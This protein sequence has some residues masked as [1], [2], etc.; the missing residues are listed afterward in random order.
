MTETDPKTLQ[1]PPDVRRYD[2]DWLR[3]IAF[4]LLIFYHIGMFYVTWGWHVKSVHAGPLIEPLMMLL[5]P[6]RLPLLFVISGVAIRFALDKSRLGRFT[7]QRTWRL[8]LPLIFGM[9][10]IVAPQ[11]WLQLMESGEI[12]KSF[13]EFYPGYVLDLYSITTPTWNHL[14]YVAYILVYTWMVIPVCRPLSAFMSGRGAQWTAKIFGGRWGVLWMLVLPALPHLAIRIWLDPHFPTTHD[15]T[16]DWANQA[17]SFAFFLTG[18]LLA[19]DSA[20]WSAIERARKPALIVTVAL[21]VVLSAAWMHWDWVTETK[22][23]L[24]PGRVGRI[25]YMWIVIAT[26]LGLSQKYLNRKSRALTYMTEAIFPWYILH[27]TL[28]V[29]AGYWLTRQGLP[30]GL[31]AA[32]VIVSTVGGCLIIH[33]V[34]VRRTG[35]VRPLFGLKRKQAKA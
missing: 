30:A 22:T 3:V 33:E 19:K 20:F 27:Q 21:G 17:H 6:W 31:E 29:M 35:L 24:W 28:I 7:A 32:L 15:M 26:L 5:N 16:N 11:S 25:A 14:W 18:Y 12:N 4:G 10:V 9:F 2:L 8:F 23:W 1:Y 34:F 13:A